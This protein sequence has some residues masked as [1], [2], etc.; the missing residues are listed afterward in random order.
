MV[1]SCLA[2]THAMRFLPLPR[3]TC[4]SVCV[5]VLFHSCIWLLWKPHVNILP[6]SDDISGREPVPGLHSARVHRATKPPGSLRPRGA[7]VLQHSHHRAAGQCD[8]SRT[9][10]V[11][12][13][14]AHLC[15]SVDHAHLPR[16]CSA[17]STE[18]TVC[19]CLAGAFAMATSL[20]SVTLSPGLVSLGELLFQ[21]CTQLKELD[22]PSS[23]TKKYSC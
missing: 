14:A 10:C 8:I 3:M 9:P 18:Q 15:C 6:R 13:C 20:T 7:G 5:S 17:V 16:K 4:D 21:G 2:D 19:T 11:L 1:C 23:L 22:L 12:Q